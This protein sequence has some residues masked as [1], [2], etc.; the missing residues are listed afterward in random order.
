MSFVSLG[1]PKNVV[2]GEQQHPWIF[3]SVSGCTRGSSSSSS[4]PVARLTNT[5]VEAGSRAAVFRPHTQHHAGEVLLGDLARAGF[6]ITTDH[7]ESDAIVVNTC[8]FVEVGGLSRGRV[9]RQ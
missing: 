3:V 5:C 6:D 2:D 4:N 9:D 8:A 7:E 1:C